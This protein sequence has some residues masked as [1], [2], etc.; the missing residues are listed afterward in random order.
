MHKVTGDRSG[1]FYVSNGTQIQIEPGSIR[2]EAPVSFVVK[3][4][5]TLEL[6]L[7]ITL[8]GSRTITMDIEGQVYGV[9][10]LRIPKAFHARLAKTGKSSCYGCN[11][12]VSNGEYWLEKLTV[13]ESAVVEVLSNSRNVKSQTIVLHVQSM[14]LQGTG[15][16]KVD[17]INIFADFMKI[18][19][20]S[21]VDSSGQGYPAYQ[22]PGYR[23]GCDKTAGAGHGG[24]GGYGRQWGC[25]TCN[26]P[27]ML[28]VY[29]LMVSR[30]I[31][32]QCV[33]YIFTVPSLFMFGYLYLKGFMYFL[34]E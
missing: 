5:G 3:Q 29:L 17:V 12:P 11:V 15:K 10:E 19:C 27:G 32:V 16:I 26:Q 28:M 34:N 22:G 6:P 4:G 14:N 20:D 13:A 31:N 30:F 21:Q 18:Q 9:E 23:S 24:D 25:S 7:F 33:C 2:S 1:V 8:R